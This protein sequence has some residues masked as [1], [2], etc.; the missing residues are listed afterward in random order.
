L[1]LLELVELDDQSSHQSSDGHRYG[2]SL[3]RP[4]CSLGQRDDDSRTE[5]ECEGF[6]NIIS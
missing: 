4:A 2:P 1:N 3:H 6:Y 5:S